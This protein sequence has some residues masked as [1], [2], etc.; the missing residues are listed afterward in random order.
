VS[1]ACTA[2]EQARRAEERRTP[3]AQH[4]LEEP[5]SGAPGCRNDARSSRTTR[6][7]L[8]ARNANNT[9]IA[10]PRTIGWTAAIA[11]ELAQPLEQ[12]RAVGH[13]LTRQLHSERHPY[14]SLDELDGRRR[15]LVGRAG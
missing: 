13:D 8:T 2:R 6:P 1:T 10:A 3:G 15:V 11:S 9:P 14:E 7:S 12:Q 4:A 5:A